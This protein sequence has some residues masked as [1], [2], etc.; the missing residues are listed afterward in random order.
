M[1]K[2][3][4]VEHY[5][6]LFWQEHNSNLLAVGAPVLKTNSMQQKYAFPY[7]IVVN[8]PGRD[9]A[10]R[11]FSFP[12]VLRTITS[13]GGTLQVLTTENPLDFISYCAFGGTNANGVYCIDNNGGG[14]PA[15]FGSPDFDLDGFSPYIN[16]YG[17]ITYGPST[18]IANGA[19]TVATQTS[20]NVSS[21]LSDLDVGH[22]VFD[23]TTY[24]AK[25]YHVIPMHNI[26]VH[27]NYPF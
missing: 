1:A 9:P 16:T 8:L 18:L 22:I 24:T 10:Y 12:T 13:A 7:S 17:P 27:V 26:S 23:F 6:T 2:L 4:R 25:I 19:A 20:S 15:N 11:L 21:T 14:G 3:A 5:S